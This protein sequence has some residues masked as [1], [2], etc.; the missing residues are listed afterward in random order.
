MKRAVSR[1]YFQKDLLLEMH[2]RLR[3]K[4]QVLTAPSQFAQL[5]SESQPAARRSDGPKLPPAERALSSSQTSPRLPLLRWQHPAA[6]T[7]RQ[8]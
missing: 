7:E 5:H 2:A 8:P 3:L 1:Q 4:I 6:A